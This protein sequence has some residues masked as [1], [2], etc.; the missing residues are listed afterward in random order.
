MSEYLTSL[1]MRARAPEL[2]VGPRL[3]SIFEA[4]AGASG[5]EVFDEANAEVAFVDG[6]ATRPA[7]AAFTGTQVSQFTAAPDAADPADIDRPAA[8]PA[9]APAKDAARMAD[10]VGARNTRNSHAMAPRADDAPGEARASSDPRG[11]DR[12]D[13][14]QFDSNEISQL[15]NR[16]NAKVGEIAVEVRAASRKFD[17]VAADEERTASPRVDVPSRFGQPVPTTPFRMTASK[18]SFPSEQPEVDPGHLGQEEPAFA[19]GFR[20]AEISPPSEVAEQDGS[21]VGRLPALATTLRS[22]DRSTPPFESKPATLATAPRREGE[23]RDQRFAQASPSIQVTIGRIE[24]RATT[25]AEPRQKPKPSS[26][27]ASLD[28]YLR[29]RSGRSGS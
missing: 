11:Q 18:G 15:P 1:V 2:S 10:S 13:R 27:A 16:S 12:K 24:V 20:Q 26:G 9:R 5:R 21:A 14:I 6:R 25:A 22:A 19:R 8:D 17:G 3:S 29:H 23:A 4:P 28:D 7:S